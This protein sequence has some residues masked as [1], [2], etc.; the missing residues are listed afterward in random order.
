M[1]ISKVFDS[2]KDQ[3][4]VLKGRMFIKM[5]KDANLISSSSETNNL[6]LIF[7]KYKSK[8][9]GINY[10]QFLKSLKDVSKV[11][12]MEPSELELKLKRTNGPIYKGTETQPVRLYD[13]K[14]LYTGVHLHGGPR[15]IDK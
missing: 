1:E 11:L 15:I 6:D 3:N 8:F 10:D 4:N 12:N 7:T 5:F 2:Y 13:D 9:S 14:S